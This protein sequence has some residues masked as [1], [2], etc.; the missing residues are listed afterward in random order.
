[1]RYSKAVT[2]SALLL[3]VVFF[4]TAL[5]L[6]A[7]D[8]GKSA[9]W[10]KVSATLK[11]GYVQPTDP[12]LYV[13]TDTCKT[14]HEDKYKSFEETRH[15]ATDLKAAKGPEWQGCEACHG[16]GKAHVDGGEITPRSSRFMLEE[17]RN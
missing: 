6:V 4:A 17:P 13:G 12:A 16:P 11:Q 10:S 9:D 3:L 8:P 7:K 15:Y 1:M 5:S 14:C 2:L